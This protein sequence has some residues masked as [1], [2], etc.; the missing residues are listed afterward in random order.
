MKE[1][2]KPILM[3]AAKAVFI[4]SF[5]GGLYL[6]L[7]TFY[8]GYSFLEMYY[9]AGILGVITIIANEFF[10]YEMDYLLQV[11]IMTT[12]GTLAEG[13][14]GLLFN[15]DFHIWDYRGLPG[16][17]FWGHCNVLFVFAWAI[18]FALVIPLIDYIDWRIF[19]YMKDTPPYYKIFGKKVFQFKE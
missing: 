15:Y 7:E 4:Y 6:L 19:H 2:L 8:R 12:I 10:S 1:R 11:L 9:L 3:Q 14:C 13:C 18:L 17:F 5:T 16:T